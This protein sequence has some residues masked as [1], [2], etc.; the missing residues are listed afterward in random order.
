[1]LDSQVQNSENKTAMKTHEELLSRRV[2][3]RCPHCNSLME[4]EEEWV[5]QAAQCPVC[6]TEIVIQ[7]PEAPAPRLT[8]VSAEPVISPPDVALPVAGI[9]FLY[10]FMIIPCTGLFTFIVCVILYF[11]R[12]ASQPEKARI[13]I[14]HTLIAALIG[15]VTAIVIP[16][17]LTLTAGM[18]L[19][20][21]ND[22]RE[23]ARRTACYSNIKQIML[24]AKMYSGDH[25][26]KFPDK[27]GAAGFEILR[28]LDYLTDPGV[29]VCPSSNITPAK[30]DRPLTERNVSYIYIGGFNE[31]GDPDQGIVFC[32]YH[33]N[34]AVVGCLDGSIRI[35]TGK[36]YN[37]V[38][39]ILEKEG[40]LKQL[41]KFSQ[42]TREYIR[43]KLGE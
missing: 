32:P 5:G 9:V 42:E 33:K 43:K 7:K 41:D 39:G 6:N 25:S 12:A 4:A 26:G 11:C 21:F 34:C 24:A 10:L 8:P 3:I 22:N 20:S 35:N 15:I 23:K 38:H 28:K 29:Y 16:F 17:V 30:D 27:S 1:M 40:I 13:L 2:Q 19:P 37:T 31:D 36:E 18:I 14:K